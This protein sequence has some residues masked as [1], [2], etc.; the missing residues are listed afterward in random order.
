M[1]HCK[2]CWKEIYP[3]ERIC[4]SCLKE[5]TDMR[6]IAHKA[7]Q[8]KYGKMNGENLKDIQKEMRRLEKLWRKDKQKFELE[9][10]PTKADTQD[11]DEG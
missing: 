7:A 11:K 5:W 2:T 10:S 8:K 9:T 3:G 6:T 1:A 4:H